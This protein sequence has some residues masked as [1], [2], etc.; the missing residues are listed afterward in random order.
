MIPW[1]TILE[2]HEDQKL[3][4][5]QPPIFS[6][7]LYLCSPHILKSSIATD[8][9][10]GGTVVCTGQCTVHT[11]ISKGRGKELEDTAT[12]IPWKCTLHTGPCAPWKA[13]SPLCAA[14]TMHWAHCLLHTLHTV[15]QAHCAGY[16][17]WTHYAL[18]KLDIAH[19]AQCTLGP[20]C[21]IWWP[22]GCHCGTATSRSSSTAATH[23]TTC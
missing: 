21:R 4:N 2:H 19:T 11:R 17:H 12:L 16:E 22:W 18:H 1:W 10:Y 7:L 20:L 3:W 13:L 5:L 14:H 23:R 9:G 6:D 8:A 15:H